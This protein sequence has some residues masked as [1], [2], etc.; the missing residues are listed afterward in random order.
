MLTHSSVL[1]L[2]HRYAW[3]LHLS[4][5]SPIGI[6]ICWYACRLASSSLDP[7][8]YW[9]DST[10]GALLA[11]IE[12]D[13]R[14]KRALEVKKAAVALAQLGGMLTPSTKSNQVGTSQSILELLR[15]GVG[16][17]LMTFQGPVTPSIIL[18]LVRLK[19]HAIETVQSITKVAGLDKCFEHET[20]SL[21]EAS[22][23]DLMRA[24]AFKIDLSIKYHSMF[25]S[26]TFCVLGLD[27]LGKQ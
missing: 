21:G 11:K 18:V 6:F 27:N 3:Y 5:P 12:M 13:L 1:I 10:K 25:P 15:H 4:V 7:T 8:G 22:L 14:R 20:K 17:G 24:I 16:K 26:F 23:F 19:Q 9:D 2:T